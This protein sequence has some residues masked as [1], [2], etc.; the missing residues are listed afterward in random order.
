MNRKE[1]I[2]KIVKTKK[3]ST[4]IRFIWSDGTETIKGEGEPVATIQFTKGVKG[5][6]E[7]NNI[8]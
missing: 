6:D 2:K 5:E 4:A 7:I 8:K 1:L 3:K